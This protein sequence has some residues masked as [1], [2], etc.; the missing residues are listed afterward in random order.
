MLHLIEATLR[1]PHEHAALETTLFQ[2]LEESGEGETL[3]LWESP[4][5]AVVISRSASIAAEVREDACRADGVPIT[6]RISGGG[7]VVVGRGCLNY[8][9]VL[10][11][12]AHPELR[13]VAQSYRAI[14]GRIVDALAVPGLTICEPGDLAVHDRK[15]SGNAQRRGRTALL[16]HGTFLYDFDV[17]LIERY[18]REPSRQPPYRR[19]R[20]HRDFVANVPLSGGTLGTRLAGAFGASI[21]CADGMMLT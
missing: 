21:R 17:G 7:A 8:A 16:H 1:G 2:T 12:D 19:G 15:V 9:L 3:S 14:L 18:L 20:R 6:R 11:L 13:E 5:P 10:S 4:Q